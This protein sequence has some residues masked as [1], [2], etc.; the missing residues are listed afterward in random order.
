MSRQYTH[1]QGLLPGVLAMKEE[2]YKPLQDMLMCRC[3]LADTRTE[4]K[5]RSSKQES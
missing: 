5:R 4:G 3:P 2:G 1:V